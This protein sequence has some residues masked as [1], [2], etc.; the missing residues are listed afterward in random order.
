MQPSGQLRR[1]GIASLISVAVNVFLFAIDFAI[2]PLRGELSRIQQLVVRLLEPADALTIRLVPGHGGEQIAA[3]V[4]FS[5][6]IYAIM[7]WVFL[8]LPV[9]W[10]TRA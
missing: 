2:D 1:L 4:A 9:W 10:R 7:G 5:F 6:V 8:S 3:L